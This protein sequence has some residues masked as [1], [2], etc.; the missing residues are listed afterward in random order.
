MR[1]ASVLAVTP[2]TCRR[3]RSTGESARP[4]TIHEVSATSTMMSGT[5]IAEQ[6][7]DGR[8]R[9]VG[10]LGVAA[11]DHDAVDRIGAEAVDGGHECLVVDTHRAGDIVIVGDRCGWCVLGGEED[12]ARLVDDLHE[13]SSSGSEIDPR[14]SD[15]MRSEITAAS[16]SAAL[17]SPS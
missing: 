10:R 14:P 4:T 8:E 1:R 13:A 3:M 11:D 5:E 2:S 9:L 17:R 12:G 16:C 6:A 15:S 7:R